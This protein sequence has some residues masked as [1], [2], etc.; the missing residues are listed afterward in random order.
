MIIHRLARGFG[1]EG[2]PYTD[3]I[4]N[5]LSMCLHVQK[6]TWYTKTLFTWNNRLCHTQG[7][8][9]FDIY[10]YDLSVHNNAE[11]KLIFLKTN[12]N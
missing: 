5:G 10:E 4:F 12:S 6:G 1:R 7:K 8:I 11:I 2:Q 9:Y 3:R